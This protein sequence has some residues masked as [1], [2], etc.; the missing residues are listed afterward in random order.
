MSDETAFFD[1]VTDAECAECGFPMALIRSDVSAIATLARVECSACEARGTIET[2][3]EES[4]AKKTGVFYHGAATKP[5][6]GSTSR[7]G[8]RA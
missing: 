4:I 7:K 2:R 5:T 6:E 1:P 8:G 3:P